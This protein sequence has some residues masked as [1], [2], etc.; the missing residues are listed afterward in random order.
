M[1]Y[2]IDRGIEWL[3]NGN[4]LDI[5]YTEKQNGGDYEKPICWDLTGAN[6]QEIATSPEFLSVL[7]LGFSIVVFILM[8]RRRLYFVS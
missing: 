2:T 8:I 4:D 7:V 6:Y 3:L 1:G 5:C